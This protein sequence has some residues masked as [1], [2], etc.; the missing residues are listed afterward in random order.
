[1]FSHLD[2]IVNFVIRSTSHVISYTTHITNLG[3]NTDVIASPEIAALG[4]NSGVPLTELVEGNTSIL[5]DLEAA[6]TITNLVELFAILVE[7]GYLGPR[8][9]EVRSTG[10]VDTDEVLG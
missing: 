9:M 10:D 6:L 7:V 5:V 1:M 4:I 2:S 8:T 3:T